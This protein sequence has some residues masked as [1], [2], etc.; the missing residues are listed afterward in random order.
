MQ[1]ALPVQTWHALKPSGGGYALFG[2]RRHTHPPEIGILTR[3]LA[4]V[5]RPSVAAPPH[6]SATARAGPSDLAAAGSDAGL[7]AALERED[8]A[9][10]APEPAGGASAA[11]V[12][13]AAPSV[14]SSRGSSVHGGGPAPVQTTPADVSQDTEGEHSS[15]ARLGS[16]AGPLFLSQRQ[17]AELGDE[18]YGDHGEGGEGQHG[19]EGEGCDAVNTDSAAG[20]LLP[21]QRQA[22]RAAAALQPTVAP[23]T[24]SPAGAAHGAP[25]VESISS[26]GAV[27]GPESI[28][29]PDQDSEGGEAQ[30]VPPHVRAGAEPSLATAAVAALPTSDA[31]AAIGQMATA[32]T[33]ALQES[34]V[35]HRPE[36][37]SVHDSHAG[38]AAP[39]APPPP[40][41]PQPPPPT[42]TEQCELLVCFRMPAADGLASLL[43]VSPATSLVPRLRWLGSEVGSL[44]GS[45]GSWRLSV[46]LSG[47]VNTVLDRMV[48]AEPP[49]LCLHA[50]D[51]D[52]PLALAGLPVGMLRRTRD[53]A[54]L[55]ETIELSA[56]LA[57]PATSSVRLGVMMR[58]RPRD[59][60]AAMAREEDPH[61]RFT[62]RLRLLSLTLLRA[63]GGEPVS[64]TGEGHR[65]GW[66]ALR[67]REYAGCPAQTAPAVRW[68]AGHPSDLWG[69]EL[70]LALPNP[71]F[72][73]RAALERLRAQPI[74]LELVC[75]PSRPSVET[76]PRLLAI[77]SLCLEDV[78]GG[79][80]TPLPHGQGSPQGEAAAATVPV[81]RAVELLDAARQTVGRVQMQLTL[82]CVYANR[83]ASGGGGQPREASGGATQQA[84][85]SM[86][87]RIPGGEAGLATGSAGPPG[88]GAG[89]ATS[90][91]DAPAGVVPQSHLPQQSF[92]FSISVRT[93]QDLSLPL[94]GYA[95]VYCRFA[96]RLLELQQG[97]GSSRAVRSSPPV[98]LPK[99]GEVALPNGDCVFEFA[100]EPA[101]LLQTLAH[102]P[103]LIELWHKDRCEAPQGRGALCGPHRFRH[104]QLL[105]P[106]HR[107]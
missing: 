32:G 44:S 5:P 68:V 16:A 74:T 89:W 81:S 65:D 2:S 72:T 91:A 70:T 51:T 23:E 85:C 86:P 48:G 15:D 25:E 9:L 14:P 88:D 64:Y 42:S 39:I 58:L 71:P 37:E 1:H 75:G 104:V 35:L 45:G 87:A 103:L 77:A 55:D 78:C 3:L 21:S 34:A 36:P 38:V 83:E 90:V 52:A 62:V 63:P 99:R 17:R 67:L 97:T 20:P 79:A 76:D 27:V 106:P 11:V 94:G 84:L 33:A 31:Q 4:E 28:L 41:P 18:G 59:V 101:A 69:E 54:E 95:N 24:S 82:Q 92:R 53:G 30:P 80:L 26:P 93:V 43:G 46:L 12:R 7:A 40:P 56:P 102:Q 19:E 107:G 66:C 96:Y 6:A 8:R 10:D 49:L 100:A 98:L 29:S 61:V 13:A 22:A 50:S 47:D 57:E 60:T 105:P 73:P